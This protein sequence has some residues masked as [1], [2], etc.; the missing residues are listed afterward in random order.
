[1]GFYEW[2]ITISAVLG[3]ATTIYVSIKKMIRPVVEVSHKIDMLVEHDRDQYLAI[4]RLTVMEEGMPISERLIAG[5]KYIE[6][7][8]NGEVKKYYEQLIK[9]HTK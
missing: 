2:F 6:N 1:M 3:A 7:G 5:K 9:D 8:G 4:L